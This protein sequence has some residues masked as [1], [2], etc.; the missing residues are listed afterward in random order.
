MRRFERRVG[1]AQKETYCCGGNSHQ[2]RRRFVEIETTPGRSDSRGRAK[3]AALSEQL[4]EQLDN[5][6]RAKSENVDM[7]QEIEA[8]SSAKQ[9][10]ERK[11]KQFESQAAEF[12]LRLEDSERSR[13]DTE[14]KL[15]KLNAEAEALA[16]Q[17]EDNETRSSV[18]AKQVRIC[19][20]F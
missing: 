1:S 3:Q 12:Q 10:S 5:V 19:M 20:A 7:A 8:L 17:L 14:E 15:T 18:L 11:K 13:A 16:N 2:R 9:E 6:N 4:N